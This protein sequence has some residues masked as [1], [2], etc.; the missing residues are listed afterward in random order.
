MVQRLMAKKTT[1][2]KN[3]QKKSSRTNHVILGLVLILVSL[4]SFGGALGGAGVGGL[5]L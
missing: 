3:Q 4:V 1:P 2:T 5:L